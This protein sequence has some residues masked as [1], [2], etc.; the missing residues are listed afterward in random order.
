MI[1]PLADALG[2][3]MGASRPVVD[4]GWLPHEYQ[5]GSSGQVVDAEALRRVRH[6]GA[7][8]HLVGM[9]GSNFIIAINK[10]AD[11][12]IFEVANLGVVGDLFEVVPEAHG[13]REDRQGLRAPGLRLG[14]PPGRDPAVVALGVEEDRAPGLHGVLVRSLTRR[15]DR[16]ASRR[17][18]RALAPARTAPADTRAPRGVIARRGVVRGRAPWLTRRRGGRTLVT[19]QVDS[20]AHDGEGGS[21]TRRIAFVNEKGGSGKTT[22]VANLAA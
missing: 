15:A 11:A 19:S 9:K 3:A 20:N 8:Q 5:V 14:S 6:L 4:A 21:V 16:A 2:G 22:L 10:D 17:G 1:K 13:G 7:I 18:L 12:P